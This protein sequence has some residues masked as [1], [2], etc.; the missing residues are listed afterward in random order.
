VDNTVLNMYDEIH[1]RDVRRAAD[2]A[3]WLLSI[4][5]EFLDTPMPEARWTT[6]GRV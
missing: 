1:E 2:L 6:G 3:G 4:V 5:G